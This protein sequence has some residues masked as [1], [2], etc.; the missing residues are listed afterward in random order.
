MATVAPAT[1]AAGCGIGGSL[2]GSRCDAAAV[3]NGRHLLD[4]ESLLDFLSMSRQEI[5]SHQRAASCG[6][7]FRRR[8]RSAANAKHA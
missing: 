6:T 8:S 2:S 3:R 7:T 1:S 4:L 5:E